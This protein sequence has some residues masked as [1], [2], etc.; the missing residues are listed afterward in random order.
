MYY[1]YGSNLHVVSHWAT[2]HVPYVQLNSAVIF[3]YLRANY[4]RL[5]KKKKKKSLKINNYDIKVMFSVEW[6]YKS[7][8]PI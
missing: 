7:T 4:N 5:L 6:I 3:S 2:A 8:T 1:I